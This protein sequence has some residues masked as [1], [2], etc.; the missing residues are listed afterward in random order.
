MSG[1]DTGRC[2]GFPIYPLS[3][4][5]YSGVERLKWSRNRL[6][7]VSLLNLDA[8]HHCSQTESLDFFFFYF[9]AEF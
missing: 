1:G 8:S 7:R 2:E 6:Q 4:F 5:N 9:S 3:V